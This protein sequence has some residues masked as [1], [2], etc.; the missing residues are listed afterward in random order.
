[1]VLGNGFFTYTVS[2]ALQEMQRLADCEVRHCVFPT[3]GN[4]QYYISEHGDLFSTQTIQGRCLTRGPKKA[5][6]L[7]GHGKRK[8]GGVTHR[9]SYTPK[10]EKWIPAEK[11]VYCTFVLGQWV[12]DLELEFINGCSTDIRPD[13]IQPKK[14][15][16][17]QEWTDRMY[18]YAEIYERDFNNVVRYIEYWAWIPHEDAK[19]VA[20]STFIWLTTVGFKSDFDTALW[21]YWG[22][23]RG[24]DLW[25][26][27]LRHFDKGEFDETLYD[28]IG[29]RP[30]EVD[31]V[32]V[33]P[34]E[35]RARYLLMWLQNHTPTE[36][37]DECNSTISNVASS[38]TRSIQFLQK[39][40]RHEKDLLR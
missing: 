36:I 29:D 2:E 30:Y 10:N 11:L 37:A 33:Q 21:M 5:G 25:N 8:D 7:E 16:C 15:K 18:Q 14:E 4:L 17:L 9:L 1:M 26:H 24:M 39:Y 28:G 38:V 3:I 27:V 22:K 20:Q 23:Y 12:E 31:L 6:S 35:K 13:N 34:G 19:D 40:L 32:H